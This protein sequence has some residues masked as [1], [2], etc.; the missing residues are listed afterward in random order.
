[1]MLEKLVGIEVSGYRVWMRPG[2]LGHVQGYISVV[3]S[4][5]QGTLHLHMLMWIENTPSSGELKSLL[6]QTAFCEHIILYLKGNIHAYCTGIELH[7]IK[8]IPRE[9]DLAWSRPPD[10]EDPAFAA[11]FDALEH[12]L[13]WL[14]QIHAC[15]VG[16]CLSYYGHTGVLRC[17]HWAP[18]PLS[19]SYDMDHKGNWKVW[20]TYGYVNNY[21]P[22]L[23]VTLRCNQDIKLLTNGK[24][25]KHV[26]W[27]IS[28]YATKWQKSVYNM[29]SLIAKYA[30]YHFAD[31][32]DIVDAWEHTQLLLFWCLHATNWDTEQSGPSCILFDWME[33]QVSVSSICTIILEQHQGAFAALVWRSWKPFISASVTKIF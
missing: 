32:T 1:M 18:W 6:K 29:L 3:E 11:K 4:Q 19:D 24:D 21:H 10:P 27:Y 22:K 2:V 30:V 33:Q 12:H 28:N 25:T 7:M 20:W 5:N 15:N 8:D 17:K 16:T 26:T 14:N 31:T 13:M 9:L 23:L